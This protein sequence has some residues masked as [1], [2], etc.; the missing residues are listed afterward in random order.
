[1]VFFAVTGQNGTVIDSIMTKMPV[2]VQ[3]SLS[4]KMTGV[5]IGSVY[6]LGAPN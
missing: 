5:D 6:S 3:A 1:M 4:V 2:G